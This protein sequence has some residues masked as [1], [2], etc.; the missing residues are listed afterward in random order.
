MSTSIQRDFYSIKEFAD[1]L[2]FH[3]NTIRRAIKRGKIQAFKISGLKGSTY[4]IPHSEIQRVA[5][6]DMEDI[7]EMILEKRKNMGI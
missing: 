1:R 5:I 3:P 2:G 4:R 6:K 7:I